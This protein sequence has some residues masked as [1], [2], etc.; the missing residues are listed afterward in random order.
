MKNLCTQSNK[1]SGLVTVAL[2]FY[3]AN[4]EAVID[5]F[6]KPGINWHIAVTVYKKGEPIDSDTRT[7][8]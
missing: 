3:L 5:C 4:S 2:H 7:F 8:A 1:L 6:G